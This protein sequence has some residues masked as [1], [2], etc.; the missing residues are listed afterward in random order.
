MPLFTLRKKCSRTQYKFGKYGTN[1]K[2]S[3]VPYLTSLVIE[4]STFVTNWALK[5]FYRCTVHLDI[6]NVFYLPT[7]ALYISLTKY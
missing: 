5:V 3:T 1:I 6:I 2:K 4:S 7:D